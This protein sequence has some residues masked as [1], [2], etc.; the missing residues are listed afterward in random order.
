MNT[1][2][3][4]LPLALLASPLAAQGDAKPFFV[5]EKNKGYDSLQRAVDAIGGGRGTILIAPGSYGDCA[6]QDRG[7]IAYVAREPGT[8]VFDGG[9][10]ESKATLVLGGRSTRVEGLVFQN[11]RVPD[12]NGAGIRIEKGDLAISETLFRD[13]ENGILSARDPGG[14]VT[15][16][17]STFSGLG[18][19]IDGHG[20]SHGLYIGEYGKLIVRRS[21]FE[22]GTGGHYL[23][24][25]TREVEI[26]DSSFDDSHGRAT[27][28]MIDLPNGATGLVARN[29]FVQG[30]D[31][32]NYSAFIMVAA[33]NRSNSASGL[34]VTD[35]DAEIAPGIDRSSSFVADKSGEPLRVE[36]NRL[37]PRIAMLERR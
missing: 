37:G 16:D 13:S 7:Q 21:R 19:C 20:C 4:L 3:S 11:L 33:E 27:N 31:K 14:T 8:A 23:K 34:T 28:Y 2:L 1:R 5:Q 9:I 24:S 17:R 12:K 29:M 15:I 30:R 22:R 6:V 25:R 36:N 35:N 18:G 32:E 26:T 10:C